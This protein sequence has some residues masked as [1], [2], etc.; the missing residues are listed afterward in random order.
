MQEDSFLKFLERSSH[1]KHWFLILL[2]CMFAIAIASYNA[3]TLKVSVLD[4]IEESL[5]FDGTIYPLANTFYWSDMKYEDWK[6]DIN[7]L[8]V[9]YDL[10]EITRDF[11]PFDESKYLESLEKTD[12]QSSNYWNTY[13]IPWSYTY[14]PKPEGSHPGVDIRGPKD[15]PIYSIANAKVIKVKDSDGTV[16]TEVTG[17][18]LDEEIQNIYPCYLHLNFRTVSEGDI[19]KKGEQIGAVGE[20]GFATTPHLHLQIDK[21]T[22]PWHP[23][24]PFSSQESSNVGLSFVEAV[25][26]GLGIENMK[27]YTIDPME[28]IQ[29]NLTE[30]N[31]TDSVTANNMTQSQEDILIEE[32]PAKEEDNET[33]DEANPDTQEGAAE[34]IDITDNKEEIESFSITTENYYPNKEQEINICTLDQNS[35]KTTR[36]PINDIFLEILQ[37]EANLSTNQLSKGKFENGCSTIKLTTGQTEGEIEIYV[38]DILHQIKGNIIINRFNFADLTENSDFFDAVEYAFQNGITTGYPDGSFKPDKTV[39]RIEAVAF[40]IRALKW[41]A[42]QNPSFDLSDASDDQWYAGMLAKAINEGM[43]NGYPDGTVRLDATVNGAEFLKMFLTAFADLRETNEGEEWYDKFIEFAAEKA[44]I[45]NDF[46]ASAP[47]DR[48]SVVNIIYLAK[49]L[50]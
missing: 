29:A 18:N 12:K 15:L 6:T 4:S 38:H 48:A 8:E 42:I 24:W 47:L 44:I 31:Y 40:I 25:N 20:K 45:Q 49:D 50:I 13:L 46:N 35:N 3:K 14:D 1:T 22:A 17:V 21:A 33:I 37:G 10:Q 7:T 28:F 23:Y 9:N 34:I 5:P 43:V 2:F 30:I 36:K 11:F 19:I 26:A 41:E 39:S 32:E 16:C 27:K